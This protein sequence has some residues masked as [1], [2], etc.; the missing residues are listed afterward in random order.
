M[1]WVSRK[2]HA[3]R[4]TVYTLLFRISCST[5]FFKNAF[6]SN[7]ES[8]LS[9]FSYVCPIFWSQKVSM[10]SLRQVQVTLSS[11]L[12]SQGLSLSSLASKKH[13]K[14]H[15]KKKPLRQGSDKLDGLLAEFQTSA[16]VTLSNFRWIEGSYSSFWQVKERVSLLS[17]RHATKQSLFVEFLPSWS[18]L[19]G[20]WEVIVL[21][22]CVWQVNVLSFR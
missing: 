12:A 7:S 3:I 21:S 6:L 9:R 8:S 22:S 17:C 15:G 19:L 11:F 13:G 10:L 20:F 2:V 1:F 16:R 5:S 14:K 18:P 4:S